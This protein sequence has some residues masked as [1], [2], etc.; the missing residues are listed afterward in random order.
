[1]MEN[2]S[3]NYRVLQKLVKMGKILS[4]I[5]FV[6]SIIGICGCVVGLLSNVFGSGKI[7]KIGGVTIYGLLADFDAYNV[8]SIRAILAAW[9]IVCVGQAVIAK[10]AEFYFRDAMAAGTPF[11]QT[12]AKEL[13][14][15]GIMMIIIPTGCTALA[16]VLQEIM[17]GFMNM[18][19]AS[20]GW[21]ALNFDNEATVIMGVMFILCSF[22]CGYGADILE[23]L[24]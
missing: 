2:K 18:N 12:G 16:E 7:F 5:A 23:D 15:L 1:M 22:I 14:K 24:K 11:T 10:F 20:D 6:V 21:S 13:R 8:K 4:R 17:T 19:T 3:K 9:L